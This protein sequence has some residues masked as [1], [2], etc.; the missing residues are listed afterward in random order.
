MTTD[1]GDRSS[2]WIPLLQRL[3]ECCPR[4]GIWKNAD[5]A[6][7]GSG[8]IDST[9]PTE[10]WPVITAEFRQWARR[11]GLGP[12]IGCDHVRG[13]L[14]LVALDR[15]HSTFLE[16]DVNARKY[17]RGWTMFRPEDLSS[18]M[19]VDPRGFRRVRPGAEGV[20]L[21][22]QNGL[23]WGGR[24]N[25]PG[26]RKRRIDEFL[27]LDPEGVRRTADL[28]GMASGTMVS[29]AEQLVRGK[30]DRRGLLVLEVSSLLKALGEPQ[31]VMWRLQSRSIKKRCPVLR[32]IFTDDRR[33][34]P[35][36]DGWLDRVRR[37]HS[38]HG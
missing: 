29:A 7:N 32:A 6:L 24:P 2:L 9:A 31:V 11:N 19:E 28:F 5:A 26:L 38:V 37:Y 15:D 17:F 22:V 10:D 3:T 4:W 27:R 8:D 12:V 23:K 35:D 13:V 34:P 1:P 21:L 14:F 33:L 25:V 36:I 30:W 20:I 18:V 16:L